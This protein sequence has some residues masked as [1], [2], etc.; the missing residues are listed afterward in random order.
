MQSIL[1]RLFQRGQ[2]LP[3]I[4][5]M[6]LDSA[7]KTTL[8]YKIAF[9]EITTIIP[10]IGF[11]IDTANI[12]VSNRLFTARVADAGGCAKIYPLVRLTMIEEGDVSAII[13]VVDASL[14]KDWL[15]ASLEEL[16]VLLHGPSW[17][18]VKEHHLASSIPILMCAPSAS[19]AIS[20]LFER[21][22]TYT[23]LA[24]KIDRLPDRKVTDEFRAR[25]DQLLQGRP[26]ACFGTAITEVPRSSCGLEQA[27][28]WLEVALTA[29]TT[30][31]SPPSTESSATTRQKQT[32]TAEGMLSNMRAPAALS[33]KLEDWLARADK[34]DPVTS[35]EELL[36]RFYALDLPSWDHFIHLRLAYIL[37]LKYG[38][39]E[40]ILI[41]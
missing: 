1:K 25:F 36:R 27:F 39:K 38:R 11:H 18:R 19:T 13:W 7:G 17:A 41:P 28:A 6:G 15:D 21:V 16:D 12:Q 20:A 9:S 33:A 23:R 14:D 2:T 3:N 24:N 26:H 30:S 22:L 34:E 29:S 10:T 8:L 5:I 32:T 4:C 40:G 31:S 35:S 37:L